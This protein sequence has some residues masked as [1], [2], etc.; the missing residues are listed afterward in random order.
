VLVWKDYLSRV[1]GLVLLNARRTLFLH[2]DLPPL[3]A[4]LSVQEIIIDAP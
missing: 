2:P 3:P 4:L 1:L